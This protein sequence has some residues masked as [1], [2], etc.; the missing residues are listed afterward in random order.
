MID[1]LDFKVELSKF[2]GSNQSYHLGHNSLMPYTNGVKYLIE[3]LKFPELIHFTNTMLEMPE[4]HMARIMYGCKTLMLLDVNEKGCIV[5]L[6]VKD[7][8]FANMIVNKREDLPY[9]HVAMII[10]SQTIYLLSED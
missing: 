2:D 5:S 10:G 3:T 6:R 1:S 9:T 8:E 7:E 4:F